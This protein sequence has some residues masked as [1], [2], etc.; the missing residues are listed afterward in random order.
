MPEKHLQASECP[1]NSRQRFSSSGA[2]LIY[3]RALVLSAPYPR[4]QGVPSPGSFSQLPTC[5]S[6]SHPC[7][8]CVV[9]AL[10]ANFLPFPQFIPAVVQIRFRFPDLQIPKCNR[11]ISKED[12]KALSF[13]PFL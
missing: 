4:S 1:V 11:P 5:C 8:I 10:T 6:S 3:T 9:S 7:E 2:V 13:P 12:F